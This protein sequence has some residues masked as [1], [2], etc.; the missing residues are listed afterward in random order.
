MK[1][2]NTPINKEWFLYIITI[3]FSGLLIDTYSEYKIGGTSIFVIKDLVIIIISIIL[4]TLFLKKQISGV[5]T[6]T[7]IVYS[8]LLS[9]G[10]SLPLKI[11]TEGFVF[12]AFFLK[13]ELILI[14]LS[15][16]TGILI[17]PIH[18]IIT[19]VYN[20]IFILACFFY[21]KGVYPIEKIIFYFIIATGGGLIGY[22][23]QLKFI[24]LTK[25]IKKVNT[26]V[27]RKNIELYKINNAKDHLFKIIGHDLKTPFA[28]LTML[29]DLMET[30]ADPEEKEEI[31]M[32]MKES[33]KMGQELLESLLNWAKAQS[34][35]TAIEKEE[36]ELNQIVNKALSFLSTNS[37][38]K[39]INITNNVPT[40]LWIEADYQMTE[41][42]LRNVIS[43][44]IKF[45]EKESPITINST[46]KNN[47]V[48]I[49][50]IDQGKGIKD[51]TLKAIMNDDKI[52]PTPGTLMESGTGFGLSICRRLL[53]KQN[54]RLEIDSILNEGTTVNLYLPLKG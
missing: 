4:V 52:T 46:V 13:A 18:I 44:A 51:Q 6:F 21:T 10:I 19:I 45:S 48:K 1:L 9:F 16:A 8:I 35:N 25:T 29:I 5:L 54:G 38:S 24:K 3:I 11:G 49:S 47:E 39:K 41:T 23:I 22:L 32:N 31:K 43:N 34:L 12:E 7:V 42:V 17:T 14:L 20:T 53:E 36:I 33:A 15:F 28:Q 27:K 26:E 37:R 40:N 2:H 50:I 30:T